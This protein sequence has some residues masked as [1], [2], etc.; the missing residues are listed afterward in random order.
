M[1]MW[2]VSTYLCHLYFVSA[3]FCSLCVLSN[4]QR[5]ATPW[6]VACRAPLSTR[7]SRQESWSGLPF[8]PPGDLPSPGNKPMSPA[9]PALADGFFTTEPPGER[10]F[11]WP[12]LDYLKTKLSQSLDDLVQWPYYPEVTVETPI[13]C[14][15]PPSG[16]CGQTLKENPVPF[17]L[18]GPGRLSALEN[19]VSLTSQSVIRVIKPVFVVCDWV[20]FWRVILK[21]PLLELGLLWMFAFVWRDILFYS[22]MFQLLERYIHLMWK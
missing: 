8:P 14:M 21:L 18:Q 19:R 2:C 3:M 1:H 12:I 17:F 10:V 11:S 9:S 4:V 16:V 15:C 5:C 22:L 20:L 7:F 13:G 6:T